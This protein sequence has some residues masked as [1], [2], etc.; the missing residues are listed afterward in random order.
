MKVPLNWSHLVFKVKK[1]HEVIYS[2]IGFSKGGVLGF[3]L[4]RPYCQD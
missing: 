1:L 3:L 4:I 2:E